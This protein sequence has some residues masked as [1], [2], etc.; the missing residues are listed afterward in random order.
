M[1][2][3]SLTA[4]IYL[5]GMAVFAAVVVMVALL[6][7]ATERTSNAFVWVN[8]TQNVIR[9]VDE[10]V[11]D[12]REAESGQRG[13]LLSR[14]SVFLDTFNESIASANSH[15]NR[16]VELTKDNLAQHQRAVKLRAGVEEKIEA[17][18]VPL[19]LA[20]AGKFDD[21]VAFV[22]SGRGRSLMED[23][24]RRAGEIK[25]GEQSLLAIR[26][27]EARERADWN[28]DLLRYGGPLVALLFVVFVILLIR[29]VRA[30]LTGVLASM[31]AFGG[32]NL[33]VRANTVTGTR[34]FDE[35]ART[36]NEM[37]DQLT[38]AMEQQKKSD[39][40]LQTANDE[41]RARGEMLQARSQAIER[42]GGMAHR[43]QAA[44]TD[45]ELA[46]V[47]RC[48]LPQVLPQTPG[49]LYIHNNSRTQLTKM[50]EWG[51]L[52]DL[53]D[54]FGPD[55]CWA[56]RRGQSHALTAHGPDVVCAHVRGDVAEYHC[57]PVLAGG[58]VIGL[59]HLGGE[60]DAE[61]SFRLGVLTENI[62]LALV[63]HKLQ[64]GLREQSIRD[65]LT[66]LFNRRYMEETLSVEVARSMRSEQSIGVIMCDVDHFKRFNDTFGHD[67]GDVLLRAVAGQ[68]QSHFRNGD[69]ACRY[70]GEEF[71]IIA[72]GASAEHLVRRAERLREGI[73]S[74]S[75]HHEGQSLGQVTMSFGVASMVAHAETDGKEALRHADGALYQAKRSGRDRVVVADI[76]APPVTV[77]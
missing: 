62:A 74:M 50:A 27:E 55:E 57:E 47:L 29:S 8:H 20:Q 64:R 37:A 1:L 52:A 68:I 53:P 77:D 36:H 65:P 69:I 34:E 19:A 6:I 59:L 3:N 14:S 7:A 5:V 2:P 71:A 17:L 24:A 13:Y 12:L 58:E 42:L 60:V 73:R 49:A 40:E 63:N 46:D 4:R 32:G 72:P 30:P 26:S 10:M 61:E 51:D 21:A 28:R 11:G 56:L 23:V 67:A 54:G 44:R 35:L 76:A 33:S 66:N 18:N 75:I 15:S 39:Q 9:A 43:M 25:S 22:R 48:F 38:A 16:L 41:L 45:A 70:G 31:K